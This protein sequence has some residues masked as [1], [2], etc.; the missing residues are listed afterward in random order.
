MG[1]ATHAIGDAAIEMVIEVYKKLHQQFPSAIKRIEHLGLPE[2]QH[3]VAMKEN[4]IACSMQTIF[5]DE[6]GKNFIKYLDDNYLNQ[7]YPVK[8]VLQQGILMALSSD[9]PVVKNFNPTKGITAAV[10]RKNNEGQ[11]I[12]PNESISVAEALKAYTISAAKISG[13]SRYGSLEKGK[14]ADFILLDK[15]P[16][17]I[18]VDEINTVKVMK[19]FVDGKEVWNADGC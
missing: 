14:L 9:A 2:K 17:H 18:P 10:T 3:L 4:N 7:C 16:L 19:T 15:N 11:L 6:L 13:E 1:V 5:I 12:A 8:S